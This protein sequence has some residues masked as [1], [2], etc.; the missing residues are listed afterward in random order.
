MA[1][2]YN[3]VFDKVT[4]KLQQLRVAYGWVAQ[5]RRKIVDCR[6]LTRAKRTVTREHYP[7]AFAVGEQ[8]LLG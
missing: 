1:V 3:N 6:S 4:S 7:F 2:T 8:L 5:K